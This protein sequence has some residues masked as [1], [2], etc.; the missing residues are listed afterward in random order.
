MAYYVYGTT[1][2]DSMVGSA[3]DDVI[4]GL[5]GDDVLYGLNGEDMIDGGPGNDKMNGGPNSDTFIVDSEGDVVVGGGANFLPDLILSSVTCILGSDVGNLT[6]TGTGGISGY[7]NALANVMKGNGGDNILIGAGG[8]DTLDGAAGNDVVSGDYGSDT[9]LFGRGDGQ[10]TLLDSFMHPWDMDTLLFK[11]GVAV[12]DIRASRE[13]DTLILK[14][15]GTDD[16]VRMPN[17]FKT[18]YM[19]GQVKEIRFADAPATVWTASRFK[20]LVSLPPPPPVVL[21]DGT[22]A[23][24]T[25]TGTTGDDLINGLAGNDVIYG[26][27]GADTLDGGAGDDKIDGGEGADEMWGGTGN[28]IYYV[29]NIHDRVNERAGE[30]VDAV[31]IRVSYTLIE[32]LENLHLAGTAAINGTGNS[33]NNVITGNTGDNV[34]DGAAGNDTMYGGSGNDT[35]IIDC[36]GDTVIEYANNGTDLV[37]SNVA[38]ALGA[39]VE[40]LTL[41]GSA[42]INGT[43]NALD[44]VL[45]GNTGN[46]QLDGGAGNDT[47]DGGAGDDRIDGGEGAD[48]MSGGT[49]NDFYVVDNANDR[50]TEL[51]GEGVDAVQIRVSHGLGANLE[52]LHLAGTAAI[53]GTGNALNN[54]ITG[55]T[56]DNVL[57]GGL[58]NDAMYGSNGNDTYVVDSAGDTVIEYLNQGVDLVRSGVSFALD[59]NIENLT[60]TGTAAINGTGNELGNALTGNSANNQLGGGAGNDR[61]EGGAGADLVFGGTGNDTYVLARGHGS[62]V[63]VED[64]GTAGNVDVALFGPGIA[65][66]QLWFSKGTGSNDLLVSVIGTNDKFTIKNWYVGNRYHVEEFKTSDGKVLLDSQVQNL[67]QAMAGFSPP[68]AGQ[69]TLPASYQPSLNPVIAANWH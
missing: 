18:Q 2:A 10:D 35:F 69:T 28:D 34:L 44:N 9:I 43:G 55:N 48:A 54:V 38:F 17:Y 23:P 66:D 37:L 56:G 50:V 45:K 39:N 31:Q 63:L 7:G 53:N 27:E 46:N 16:Q 52:N 25:L 13:G 3:G 26:K 47:L 41:T 15:A 29:D 33:L 20:D 67:V 11:A 61:L 49:G 60:L 21:I 64:D 5:E 19:Y 62:D 12:A 30:G 24:D 57:D 58:G 51:A 42:A 40:N 4:Y 65:M 1:G 8:D 32:N 36:A 68:A 59:P 6:L 22:P 14:I